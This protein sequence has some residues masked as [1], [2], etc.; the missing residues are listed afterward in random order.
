MMG[1]ILISIAIIIAIGFL[2]LAN[3]A[4]EEEVKNFR[5]ED[6]EHLKK[7]QKNKLSIKGRC[8]IC[9]GKKN[10]RRIIGD[11]YM[12]ENICPSEFHGKLDGVNRF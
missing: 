4:C 1:I 7:K 8:V 11:E 9:G 2:I 6:K 12:I 3:W 5:K 10:D